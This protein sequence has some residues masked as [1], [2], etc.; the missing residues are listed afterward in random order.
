MQVQNQ[1]IIGA[2]DIHEKNIEF[3]PLGH[4]LNSDGLPKLREY[5]A[6]K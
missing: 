4:F 2:T 6:W 3:L 5:Q 1:S